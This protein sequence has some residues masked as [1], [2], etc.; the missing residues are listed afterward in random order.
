MNDR[1]PDRAEAIRQIAAVFAAAMA[2]LDELLEQTMMG[3]ASQKFLPFMVPGPGPRKGDNWDQTIA[4]NPIWH[5]SPPELAGAGVQ[6]N[7]LTCLVRSMNYMEMKVADQI[8]WGPVKFLYKD[9]G[10]EITLP[11]TP[12]FL[13]RQRF[14]LE[15]YIPPSD[16]GFWQLEAKV[17]KSFEMVFGYETPLQYP[18]IKP[19]KA[20]DLG[21]PE[22]MGPSLAAVFHTDEGSPARCTLRLP[23][24]RI[25][26]IV[27]LVTCKERNN[28]EPGGVLG[29]GRFYPMLLMISNLPLESITGSVKIVRNSSGTMGETEEM[30]SEV[31]SI[32]MT[33][34]NPSP[35]VPFPFWDLF[36]S[37]YMIDPPNGKYTMALPASRADR[38]VIPEAVTLYHEHLPSGAQ[39]VLKLAGQG[40]FDSIHIAPRMRVPTSKK[41]A[42]PEIRA[43]LDQ[44][45]MAPFCV[46]DCLHMHFRWGSGSSAKQ[47][48]GWSGDT[49]F[50]GAGWPLVQGNQTVVLD[51]KSPCSGL[52]TATAQEVDSLRWQIVLHHGLAYAL[53]T[54]ATAD[55]AETALAALALLDVPEA[56][57]GWPLFYWYLRYYYD[58]S[59]K[60][61]HERLTV[62]DEQ[63][64]ELRRVPMQIVGAE[65][66]EP[67]TR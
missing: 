53:S 14:L 11:L 63:L 35:A 54:T 18:D 49:P 3:A 20:E 1:N 52:Y 59:L 65:Q 5:Y 6:V 29:A 39:D 51:L 31:K 61:F 56:K 28:F 24:L 45:V 13:V 22:L 41:G 30:H 9:F 17:D 60:T 27:T 48:K 44:I 37:Y 47:A 26:V 2:T 34:R 62:T 16:S 10:K 57:T 15:G 8:E 55:A 36:F 25:I 46:H 50:F 40:E 19:L 33:D 23:S 67:A 12:A 7:D 58:P 21:A 43:S 38:R 66:L 64:R 42:P 32:F 4:D